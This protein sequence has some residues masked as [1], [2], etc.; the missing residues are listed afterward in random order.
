MYRALVSKKFFRDH[1]YA[2]NSVQRF[3][4][5]TLLCKELE[6]V[7]ADF[8]VGHGELGAGRIADA[9]DEKAMIAALDDPE[10]IFQLLRKKIDTVNRAVLIEKALEYEAE[11][12]PNVCEKLLRSDHTTF[13]ENAIR[14]L[15]RSEDDYSAPLRERYKEIRSPYVLSLVCLVLGFRGDEHT[16]PWMMDRY[17]ELASRH[18]DETYSQ[19][20]LLALHELRARFYGG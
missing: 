19:G 6:Q 2:E 4:Y 15:A 13:I 12:M 7:A 17:R 9:A 1:P 20:P 16:I 8:L 14:L 11:I 3:V 18:P 10:A 5:S